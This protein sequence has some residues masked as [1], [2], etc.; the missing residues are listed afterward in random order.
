MRS[1]CFYLTRHDFDCNYHAGELR[2]LA[3]STRCIVAAQRRFGSG[4]VSVGWG[5]GWIFIDQLNVSQSRS[6]HYNR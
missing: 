5:W 6:P 4:T 3:S 1:S 2:E